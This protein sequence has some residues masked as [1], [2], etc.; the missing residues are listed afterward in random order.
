M[1]KRDPD[2]VRPFGG[3]VQMQLAGDPELAMSYSL[4][5]RRLL[6]RMLNASGVEERIRNGE[7]G[8]FH[9]QVH[10]LE[11]G[12]RLTAITNNG[13]HTVRIETPLPLPDAP[14]GV[15]SAH[16]EAPANFSWRHID[17]EGGF[18]DEP[19][20]LPPVKLREVED[21]DEERKK[22]RSDYLWVGIRS[23]NANVPWYAVNAIMVEP[24][25]GPLW[26]GEHPLRGIISSTA[27]WC[28]KGINL[29]SSDDGSYTA[30]TAFPLTFSDDV[31]GAVQSSYDLWYASGGS[32][33]N[34]IPGTHHISVAENVDEGEFETSANG[35]RCFSTWAT[36]QNQPDLTRWLPYDPLADDQTGAQV[37]NYGDR[38][39]HG[40]YPIAP[41]LWDIV[42]V[43]D[44]DE[45]DQEEPVESRP[46]VL[47]ARRALEKLGMRN[48]LL[49]GDYVLAVHIFDDAPQ[50][51]STRAGEEI[52]LYAGDPSGLGRRSATSDY[53]QYMKPVDTTLNTSIE[54]EVRL[55]RGTE[56][57]T[58]NFSTT[59]ASADDRE[60]AYLPYGVDDPDPCSHAGGPNPVGPNFAPQYLAIDPLGGSARWIDQGKA[61]LAPILGGG[62]YGNPGDDRLPFDIYFTVYGPSQPEQTEY[63]EYMAYALFRVFEAASAG[64]YGQVKI[65]DPGGEGGLQDMLGGVSKS[66]IWCLDAMGM[67]LEAVPLVSSVD[68]YD[69]TDQTDSFGNP[70]A[71]P[72]QPEL[73]WYYPYRVQARDACRRSVG[74]SITA[75]K[76]T[77]FFDNGQGVY[78]ADPPQTTSCC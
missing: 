20:P 52:P 13:T 42:Y 34:I 69:Y 11:D 5:G 59:V 15:H 57:I 60:Y 31:H 37:R 78:F 61:D 65:S 32:Q 29:V 38:Q 39:I 6:G 17:A 19:P 44:P 64:V 77:F 58:L 75:V 10:M 40:S 12:T 18:V 41:R 50:L 14:A 36:V 22:E 66:Q 49:P 33:L 73:F 43:C 48:T 1:S 72:Y 7:D 71:S 28:G 63:A 3:L 30:D 47:A 55:G 35:L 56:A 54:I 46:H 2:D 21:E 23:T 4:E 53:D 51:R 26:D 8:G 62:T 68:D 67:A 9:Q 70:Y 16:A 24:D 45:D 76:G 74:I 25:S 27:V